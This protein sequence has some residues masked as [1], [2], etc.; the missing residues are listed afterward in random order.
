MAGLPV[1]TGAGQAVAGGEMGSNTGGSITGGAVAGGAPMAAGQ[2]EV[3]GTPAM[4]GQS[5]PF[6]VPTGGQNS[7]NIP[8]RCTVRFVVTTPASTP[9]G[10]IFIAGTFNWP[11]P[12]DI[13]EPMA[14]D[15]WTMNGDCKDPIPAE[16]DPNA[17]RCNWNP[18]DPQLRLERSGTS[19][20]FEYELPHLSRVEYKFTRGAWCAV[21]KTNACN[22]LATNRR[23]TVNCAGENPK[24]VEHTVENWN[25]VCM[26]TQCL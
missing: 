5:N 3:G 18:G 7:A 20:T 16:A 26:N 17:L 10:N 4:G 1:E 11:T 19:A 12:Q 6:V 22:E 25:D 23:Y 9:A 8:D 21:E 24:T 14:T 2:I 15:E 13:P